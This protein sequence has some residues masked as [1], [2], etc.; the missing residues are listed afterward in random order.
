MPETRVIAEFGVRG[1]LSE[2]MIFI[3]DYVSWELYKREDKLS[4]R[5][6]I[7]MGRF[8]IQKVSSEYKRSVE[9]SLRFGSVDVEGT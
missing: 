5:E 4:E 7:K 1:G 2:H 8:Q 9:E 6:K 3:Q